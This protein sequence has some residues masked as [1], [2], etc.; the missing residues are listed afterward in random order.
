[1]ALTDL[2]ILATTIAALPTGANAATSNLAST[3]GSCNTIAMAN[4]AAAAVQYAAAAITVLLAAVATLGLAHA[5]ATCCATAT[6]A[7]E[8]S[9][10]PPWSSC[11]SVLGLRNNDGRTILNGGGVW[12]GERGADGY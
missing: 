6:V 12:M 11:Q 7:A 3:T 10:L 2:H 8:L 5:G 4:R 1:M 9:A